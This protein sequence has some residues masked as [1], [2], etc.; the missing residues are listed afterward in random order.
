[1][2]DPLAKTPDPFSGIN[3]TLGSG[4]QS[5]HLSDDG[6]NPIQVDWIKFAPVELSLAGNLTP[7]STQGTSATQVGTRFGVNVIG[8][9]D[10][11]RYYVNSAEHKATTENV[12]LTHTVKL[13]RITPYTGT[14]TTHPPEVHTLLW[15]SAPANPTNVGWNT[16]SLPTSQLLEPGLYLVSTNVNVSYNYSTLAY[17]GLPQPSLLTLVAGVYWNSNNSP[18]A[19]PD[20]LGGAFYWID[21]LFRPMY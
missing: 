6:A 8:Y 3:V 13:W 21:V 5:L 12:N 18:N 9:V 19:P 17:I 11:L 2:N 10:A 4:V 16:V 14:D 7:P 20:A 1:M 15:E